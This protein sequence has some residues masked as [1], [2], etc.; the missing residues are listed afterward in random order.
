MQTCSVQPAPNSTTWDCNAEC[1]P[2]DTATTT[3]LNFPE[4]TGLLHFQGRKESKH[5]TNLESCFH[6]CQPVP[7]G[8]RGWLVGLVVA[9]HIVV[10][11]TVLHKNTKGNCRGLSHT[12]SIQPLPKSI[13][14]LHSGN[15]S[16][17]DDR[18]LE[19]PE[20]W[21]SLLHFFLPRISLEMAFEVIY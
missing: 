20:Q 6:C 5:G 3:T 8:P 4:I 19:S 10:V 13:L 12:G 14:S 7:H 1:A 2:S 17:K 9:H 11:S 18:L 15:T 21:N 16:T